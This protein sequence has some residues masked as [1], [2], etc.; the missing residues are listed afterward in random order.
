ME[1]T[2]IPTAGSPVP[3]IDD[4]IS[5]R[6]VFADMLKE[7]GFSKCLQARDGQE[8]LQVME[9]VPVQ[10]VSLVLLSTLTV[11]SAIPSW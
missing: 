3:I 10:L 7:L 2:N 1:E 9:R 8:G 6:L 11:A 5:A 4:L